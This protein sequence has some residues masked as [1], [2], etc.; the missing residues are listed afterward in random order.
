[1]TSISITDN[2]STVVVENDVVIVQLTEGGPQGPGGVGVAAGGS[3]GDLLVRTSGPPYDT[4]WTSAP[5][6]DKLYF[7]TT[8]PLAPPAPGQTMWDA[9]EG[10]LCLGA[11]GFSYRV[12]QNLA[13]PCLNTSAVTLTPGDAVMFM[14]ADQ[15]T[16]YIKVGP[17]IANGTVPSVT[18]FGIS[19][20]VIAPDGVGY[21]IT[22][23][24]IKKID[25]SAYPQDSILFLD[26]ANPG[27]LTITEPTA[28][29][30]K[31]AC[32]VVVESHP[33]TGVIFVRT[34]RGETLNR[35]HD[36]NTGGGAEDLQYL[37]WNDND[38]VW[39]PYTIPNLAPRSITIAEPK[40]GDN[41]TLFQTERDTTLTSLSALVRGTSSPSVTYEVRYASSRNAAGSLAINSS[42]AANT[43]TGT[44][45]AVI[46]QPIPEG[47]YVW[48]VIT[49]ISGSV[50]E[51]NL[52]VR[53]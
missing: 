9:A 4:E 3:A 31:I 20:N 40:P 38:Q 44:P 18:F 51:F 33:T 27:K 49:G 39:R 14:G 12:S 28:P 41:F 16:G 37:G 53:F 17:M 32:A 5:T 15:T 6:V 43:D 35:L 45:A 2:R 7:D 50:S 22:V 1:M 25:T 47:D 10:T 42:T 26:P 30:L 34:E 24:K 21:I 13:Y 11:P 8:F 19:A 29:N 23:G 52:S 46:N 48:L 36:V